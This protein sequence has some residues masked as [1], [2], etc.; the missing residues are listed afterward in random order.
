MKTSFG[1]KNDCGFE[2]TKAIGCGVGVYK[3]GANTGNVR[4]ELADI[5][6]KGWRK[7]LLEKMKSRQER[8]EF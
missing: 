7:R 5:A 6:M 3:M 1:S 4:I 8:T 2:V